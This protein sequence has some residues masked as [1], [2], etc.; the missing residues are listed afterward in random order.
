MINLLYAGLLN[1]QTN[2]TSPAWLRPMPDGYKQLK[3]PTHME[4]VR[5][6]FTRTNVSVESGPWTETYMAEASMKLLSFDNYWNSLRENIK[7]VTPD[8]PIDEYTFGVSV[9]G[10]NDLFSSVVG[11]YGIGEL[12]R[13]MKVRSEWNLLINDD[14]T[15]TASDGNITK[16][17][18][19]GTSIHLD[20]NGNN[21]GLSVYITAGPAGAKGTVIQT[22]RLYPT[23]LQVIL[24]NLSTN[25]ASVGALL[26]E[27]GIQ[28]SAVGA[29]TMD[30]VQA[31]LYAYE[32]R[33]KGL[34]T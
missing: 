11:S 19:V 7:D 29:F 34:T 23:A 30:T 20:T 21:T 28:P 15:Y 18:A 25:T 9:F 1:W 5:R 4:V 13:V 3:L 10:T 22:A 26:A 17:T 8:V 32:T 33:L 16:T 12:V 31:A 24:D 2:S 27:V 6:C 14:N